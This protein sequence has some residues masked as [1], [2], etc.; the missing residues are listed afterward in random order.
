[1]AG[2]RAAEQEKRVRRAGSGDYGW[3]LAGNKL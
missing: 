3:G 2:A 1:M